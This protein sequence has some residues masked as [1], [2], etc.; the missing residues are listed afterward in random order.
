MSF[1]R[2]SWYCAGWCH[3]ID[4]K[5]KGIRILDEY[6]V[7]YRGKAGQA[8]AM[9]GRCPHRFAPLDL[10]V[11]I[12]DDILCP[13]HGLRF[14]TDGACKH[15]PHGDGFIPSNAKLK[16]YVI[17]EHNTALWV[18]MGDSNLADRALLPAETALMS[19]EYSSERMAL[20]LPVNYQ[21]V[22]DNLLDLT[23][24]PY[25]H[26]STLASTEGMDL[27]EIPLPDVQFKRDGDRVSSS[28]HY[29]TMPP[30]PQL[31]PYFSDP[32]GEFK[33]TMLWQ[34]ASILT[35]DLRMDPI[36]GGQSESIHMPTVHYITP[37]TDKTT[38]YFAAVSRNRDIHNA[39]ADE[40]MRTIVAKAFLEE[41]EPMISRCQDLM[42]GNAD[43]FEL[44]AAILRTDVAGV[45]A[46]RVLKQKIDEESAA[47]SAGV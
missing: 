10:G 21:L 40:H 38:H 20:N 11:V 19:A 42:G 18:W 27:S 26:R 22:V 35:L 29:E 46:R 47:Q 17:A 33:A 43:I 7:I 28:Y 15:N 24:A 3:E 39:A 4:E 23:H 32:V 30:S 2:N 25:L 6:V 5:P 12:D 41:D 14:G 36:E 34:P 44:G 1:L 13:Y 8:I 31:A 9:A 45:Q 37:E 16:T